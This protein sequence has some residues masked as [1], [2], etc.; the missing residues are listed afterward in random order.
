MADS[1]KRKKVSIVIGLLL[2]CITALYFFP[3]VFSSKTFASRD[4][5]AF[6][7]PRQLFAAQCIKS[8]I[9]PLWNPHL[10]SGVPF[11]AN[12]QSSVFYPLSLI[13]YILPFGTGFKYFI[14]LHY[15][16]A[17]V[18]MF[19]LMRHWEY[20]N[21]AGMCSAIV[22][23]FGGYMISILDNVAFLTAAV[24]LPLIV[25]AYARFLKGRNQ[26]YLVLTGVLIGLQIL[27]GDASCY[28]IVDIHVYDRLSSF[29]P[30][31]RTISVS[32]IKT[33]ITLVYPVC[34]VNWHFAFCHCAYPFCR[35]CLFFDTSGRVQL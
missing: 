24:W 21:Y 11:L 23:M 7:Y 20:D 29:L 15:F 28:V 2:L 22:F 35:I 34:L 9:L 31:F 17:G 6:F 12:L 14:V 27:A 1:N 18:G 30:A 10:A 8:G 4:M 33:P 13:Y 32:R 19:L 25:L 5:Y 16:L 3:V 26:L